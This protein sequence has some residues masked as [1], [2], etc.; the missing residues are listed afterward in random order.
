MKIILTINPEA[1]SPELTQPS[2]AVPPDDIPTDLPLPYVQPDQPVI[3]NW[4]PVMGHPPPCSCQ[5]CIARHF[6][7]PTY[8]FPPLPEIEEID[9]QD[10]HI[11]VLTSYLTPPSTNRCVFDSGAN[12]HLRRRVLARGHLLS[13]PHANCC[14]YPWN[15][16][17]ITC[18]K[19]MCYWT[20]TG[21]HMPIRQG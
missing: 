1:D 16:G 14:S 2:A 8:E 4:D 10:M 19:T 7:Y 15:L 18:Y 9:D 12:R 21:I 13:S 3:D 6:R 20:S 17:P 5:R 11:N